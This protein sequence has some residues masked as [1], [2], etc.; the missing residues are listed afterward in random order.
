[1]EDLSDLNASQDPLGDYQGF[2]KIF[3]S[4]QDIKKNKLFKAFEK[5]FG[6]TFLIGGILAFI[7]NLL[8]FSGPLMIGKILNFLNNDGPDREPLSVGLTY[9]G[10]LVGCYLLKTVI[11]SHSMYFVNLCCTKVFYSIFRL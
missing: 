4:L 6:F 8:Q 2:K 11:F 7:S 1:M 9:V 5:Y 3:Y 10:I